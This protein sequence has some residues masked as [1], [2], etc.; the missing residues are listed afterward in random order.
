LDAPIACNRNNILYAN[1]R[2]FLANR[3][4]W[5]DSTSRNGPGTSF[6]ELHT[7]R[8]SARPKKSRLVERGALLAHGWIRAV[9]S[10]HSRTALFSLDAF[11]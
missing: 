4:V 11:V 8:Y 6:V 5:R 3:S 2:E 10:R 9:H 7:N 1:L